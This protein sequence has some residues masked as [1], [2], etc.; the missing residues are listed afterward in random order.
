MAKFVSL[1]VYS[2]RPNPVWR[3]DD[4]EA[5]QLVTQ[6]QRGGGAALQVEAPVL[7][8]R[9]FSIVDVAE[10][11]DDD[12][13]FAAA[14]STAESDRLVTIY[15]DPELETALLRIGAESGQVDPALQAYLTETL[16]DS[17][18]DQTRQADAAML[19]LA[20]PPCGG[21]SAPAYDPGYWNND[22]VRLRN[23][24]CYNYANNKATNTFAQP[25]RASGG[26]SATL[27]CNGVRAAAQ[28]DGLI[29]VPSFQASN[30]GWYVALVI[31][32]GQDY[33]WYRQDRSG[34]WSHKPGQTEARNTDNAGN[35]IADPRT[36]NRGPY[37]NFCTYMT[38]K[39]NAN[40]R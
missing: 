17:G 22:Q 35:T 3:I 25:G 34:C 37:V 33:H 4:Y 5:D 12:T 1:D 23:N 27:D 30:P 28:R 10:D 16:A 36:C 18:R 13:Q 9:G 26:T 31:W 39:A 2:G 8:Y 20:C 29:A 15:G 7:G 14:R 11:G 19:D 6:T 32:P 40:I 21:G 24:N 38:T